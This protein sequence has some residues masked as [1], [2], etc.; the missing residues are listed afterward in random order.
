MDNKNNFWQ[1]EKNKA[2]IKLGL[3]IIFIFILIV[4]VIFQERNNTNNDINKPND[5][6]EEIDT[7]VYDFVN[8]N[9]MQDKLLENNYEY[10]YK[11][12]NLDS[13]YIYSG[14]KC[15]GKEIGFREDINSVIKY[16]I[17]DTGIYQIN[18]DNL[19]LIDILYQNVDTSY[20]DINMLFENLHEYLYSVDKNNDLRT[21]TYDKEGY[22]V[23]VL[24]DKSNIKSIKVVADTTTYELEFM[25]IGECEDIDFTTLVE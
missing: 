10:V 25:E 11:I 12:S 17:D 13:K 8:Y 23:T 5:N 19:V 7:P 20:L 15:N 18:L 24:T 21:I 16:Y 22:Q 9:D 4:F 2:A 14:M 6:N 3:W 1:S